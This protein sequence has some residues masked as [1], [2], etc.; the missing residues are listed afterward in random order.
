[1]FGVVCFTFTIVMSLFVF[2]EEP[3]LT[4]DSKEEVLTKPIDDAVV[5]SAKLKVFV[6]DDCVT[7]T[8]KL[9]ITSKE[10]IK[11]SCTL[12]LVKDETIERNSQNHYVLKVKKDGSKTEQ[13]I[14][15]S[16]TRIK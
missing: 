9:S 10:A 6:E 12:N 14:I 1:M 5:L 3:I 8:S 2:A 15:F 11:T 4:N 16:K 7:D 13:T